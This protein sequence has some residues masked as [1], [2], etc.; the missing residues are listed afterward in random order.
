MLN[1]FEIDA[2]EMNAEMASHAFSLRDDLIQ[3]QVDTN[4]TWNRQICNQVCFGCQLNIDTKSE[5]ETDPTC[6]QPVR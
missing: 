3:W 6:P 4:R 2:A 1:M 5:V